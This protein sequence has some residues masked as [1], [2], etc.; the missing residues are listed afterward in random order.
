MKRKMLKKNNEKSAQDE[1]GIITNKNYLEL[2]SQ[3]G[4]GKT[5]LAQV[6][7]KMNQ[8][9]ESAWSDWDKGWDD[10]DRD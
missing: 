2:I 3:K 1:K 10:W 8:K 9:H 5:I 4:K 7:R 6:I